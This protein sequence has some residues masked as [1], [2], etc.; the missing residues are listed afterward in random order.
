V[1]VAKLEAQAADAVMAKA[2]GR[3]LVEFTNVDLAYDTTSGNAIEDVSLTIR[4][5]EF[6][7]VVGP[8]GCGKSTFMK[9]VS[10]LRPPTKGNVYVDGREVAGPLKIV[11][12]AF[13]AP[14]LLPWRTTLDNVL[15]PLEIVQPYRS[16]FKAKKKGEFT[17]RAKSLLKTVGLEGN[18]SK[19][20]WQLSGGMQQRAS[21]CRALVHQPKL[22]LLDEPFGALDAFTREELWCV[23]RDLHQEKKF[24]VI[25]VTH[26]LREATFLADTI[27]VMSKRPGRILVRKEIDLPRPR[28]LE[29]TYTDRF[30]EIVHELRA[31]IGR[32]RKT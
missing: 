25:L 11:G 12:M 23:L 20:P 22:L 5:G 13:Q 16:E 3:D 10:G 27:Y 7:S 14:T 2:Q 1:Q 9:L 28:D 21:I 8:S 17:D 29:V 30:T 26:D 15:L 18:E 6:I 19:F 31:H 24:T 4:E 32:I